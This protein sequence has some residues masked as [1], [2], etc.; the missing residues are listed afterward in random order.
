ME[1]P[2]FD[3]FS[4]SCDILFDT[5]EIRFNH[6]KFAL[7]CVVSIKIFPCHLLNRSLM[8][9]L[10]LGPKLRTKL[11]NSTRV[12]YDIGLKGVQGNEINYIMWFDVE[13]TIN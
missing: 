11:A 13:R 3:P 6:E 8:L 7:Q 4:I 5:Q 2:N 1:H 12:K 9:A 10:H